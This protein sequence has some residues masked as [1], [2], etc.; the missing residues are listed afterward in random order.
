MAEEQYE[1]QKDPKV[2]IAGITMES[3][4]VWISAH[5]PVFG[6]MFRP[7]AQ[8]MIIALATWPRA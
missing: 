1:S 6:T 3:R 8:S 5:V 4:E 7:P 2:I